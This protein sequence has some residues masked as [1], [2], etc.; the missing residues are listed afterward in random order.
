M[1]PE[2]DLQHD[3]INAAMK[4]P[5][6]FGYK[7][8]NRFT[9]GVPDLFLAVPPLRPVIVEVKKQEYKPY[10]VKID[11]SA[12]QQLFLTQLTKAGQ[13]CGVC[14]IWEGKE[15][16]CHYAYDVFPWGER[17]TLTTAPRYATLFKYR[18]DEHPVVDII[19][20]IADHEKWQN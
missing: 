1:K 15:F 19:I 7:L 14:V 11:L 9:T 13:P 17:P 6:G 4:R 12:R 5:G 10:E 8:S 16:G 3:L 18:G 20:R 2:I